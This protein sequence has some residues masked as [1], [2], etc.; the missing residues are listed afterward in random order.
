MHQVVIFLDNVKIKMTAQKCKIN[1]PSHYFHSE[2]VLSKIL[3]IFLKSNA[4]RYSEFLFIYI[5]LHAI[6]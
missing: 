6:F 4:L 3:N 1:M 5:Y 2:P